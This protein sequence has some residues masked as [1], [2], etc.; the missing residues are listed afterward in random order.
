MPTY[1]VTDPETGQTL[2][3]TGDSPPSEKELEQIFGSTRSSPSQ[4]NIDANRFLNENAPGP[5]KNPSSVNRVMEVPDNMAGVTTWP[6]LKETAKAF[7]NEI[8]AESPI[9]A[10][11][12]LAAYAAAPGGPLAMIPASIAGG[13][14][15][16]LTKEGVEQGMLKSGIIKEGDKLISDY[17]EIGRAA[18]RERV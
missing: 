2:K 14:L 4:A 6:Q 17:P 9:L 12:G 16:A 8:V 10:G 13:T 15:A 1:K 5:I 18:C 7:G 3:L 11:A